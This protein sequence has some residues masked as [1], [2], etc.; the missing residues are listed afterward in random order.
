M[1]KAGFFNDNRNRSFPFR[2]GTVGIVQDI[3]EPA[4]MLHLPDSAV[5]DCGFMMGPESGFIEATHDIRLA[6]ISRAGDIFTFEFRSTTPALADTPLLFTADQTAPDYSRDFADSDIPEYAPASQSL[7][8]SV[9]ASASE[10][11][12]PPATPCGEPFWSGY[13][14]FGDLA[15][16]AVMLPDGQSLVGDVTMAVVEPAL[17]QNLNISQVVSVNIANADRTRAI[18][19]PACPEYLWP[20]QVGGHFVNAECMQGNLEFR[21]G[22]NMA[23][24]Q[25][26]STRTFNFEAIPNA[27][28]GQSCEEIPLFDGETPPVGLEDAPLSGGWLC[29][30]VVRSING[31]M[32]PAMNLFAGSGVT[33]DPNPDFY[34]NTVVIDI[35]LNSLA[36]SSCRY[37]SMSESGQ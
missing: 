37:D 1:A 29:H 24:S 30:S 18:N 35:D 11:E 4:S 13:C 27:G 7:S 28:L 33:I 9:S 6:R 32:G 10:S 17:I 25:N 12:G 8:T 3:G 34:T 21:A 23:V 19:D 14:V 36:A 15:A 20:F 5:V 2:Q 26:N 22:Y 31:I 16:L